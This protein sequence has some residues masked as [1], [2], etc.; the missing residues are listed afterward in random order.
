MPAVQLWAETKGVGDELHRALKYLR[1]F[2]R[3]PEAEYHSE[4][5][6]DICYKADQPS[7]TCQVSRR[8]HNGLVP[9][10]FLA[11]IWDENRQ[12]WSFHS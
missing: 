12:D 4:I 10:Y 8:G 9:F 3:G 6:P 7:F 5:H 2:S 11:M 1:T